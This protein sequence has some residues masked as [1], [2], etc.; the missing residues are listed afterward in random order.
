[1][2]I[3]FR[4]IPYILIQLAIVLLVGMGE[5]FQAGWS[6]G[7]LAEA[8]FWFS[9]ATITLATILSFF[10]WA[11]VKID[12]YLDTPYYKDME[13][14]PKI[15]MNDAGVVLAI[16]K[17]ILSNLIL[18][19]KTSSLADY[20]DKINLEEKKEVYIEQKTAELL[21]YRE[22]WRS[23]CVFTK[24]NAARRVELIKAQLE[25]EYIEN[26]I[27][28]LKVKYV[29]I[30]EAY[31]VNGLSVKVGKT[32]RQKIKSRGVTMMSDNI[33]KWLLSLSYLLMLTSITVQFNEELSLSAVYTVAIKVVNCLIQSLMGIAYAKD[34]VVNKSIAEIDDR[35]AIMEGYIEY[36]T[37]G[38]V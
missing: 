20:L 32:H 6:L 27:C 38:A 1:M 26:N 10:S 35:L 14:D 2:K 25:N 36:K 18:G 9:Y 5:L 29:P 28:K 22:G 15:N 11:N 33:H 8:D 30:T 23:T 34:Y 7:R 37:K 13:N 17:N 21:K 19:H 24:K 31:I 3:S 16:K 4:L 12:I